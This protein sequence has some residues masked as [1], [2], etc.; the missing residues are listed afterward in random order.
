LIAAGVVNAAALV[1]TAHPEI[2][3]SHSMNDFF[4]EIETETDRSDNY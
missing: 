2:A 4:G 1:K 3:Y